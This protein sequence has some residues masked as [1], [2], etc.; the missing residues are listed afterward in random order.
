MLED[1]VAKTAT[2]PPPHTDVDCR[3][4]QYC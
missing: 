2:K 1:E 3:H 4:H